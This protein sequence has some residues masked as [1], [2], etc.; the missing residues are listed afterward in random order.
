[1]T[2]GAIP[3]R[4]KRKCIIRR[5]FTRLETQHSVCYSSFQC[6]NTKPLQ[7]EKGK[8][9]PGPLIRLQCAVTCPASTQPCRLYTL[10]YFSLPYC[11]FLKGLPRGRAL[12]MSLIVLTQALCLSEGVDGVHSRCFLCTERIYHVTA[13]SPSSMPSPGSTRLKCE[14]KNK[15]GGFL[16]LLP[17]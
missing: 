5:P 4:A 16:F 14:Q 8:G 13:I 1:M 9:R 10:H 17:L 2:A 7:K 15:V 6:L 12:S 11:S 3:N